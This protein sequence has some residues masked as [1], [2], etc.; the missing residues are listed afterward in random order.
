MRD[1]TVMRMVR[2]GWLVND[3]DQ[4]RIANERVTQLFMSRGRE[5]DETRRW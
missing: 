4:W 5:E 1:W 3:S 2:L